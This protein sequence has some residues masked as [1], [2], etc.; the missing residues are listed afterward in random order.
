[1]VLREGRSDTGPSAFGWLHALIDH[2]VDDHVIER[3]VSKAYPLTGPR[4]RVRYIAELRVEQRGIMS[5]WVE[6]DPR[7]SDEAPD[8][9]RFGVLTAYCKLPQGSLPENKCPSWVNDSM[10]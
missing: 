2:N 3:V 5:V 6:V 10:L 1:M 9:E 7:A 4:G 8:D